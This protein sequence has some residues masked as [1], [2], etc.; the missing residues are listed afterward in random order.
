V[1][2]D[3]A[4]RFQTLVGIGASVA[5]VNA[6]IVEH[7]RKEAL[8]DAMF[9]D[10][11][12]DMLRL[13]NEHGLDEDMAHTAEIVRAAT[14]RLGH[15]PTILMN[16]ASPPPSLKANGSNW[17][18]G[19]PEDCTLVTL[20]DGSFD[21][22]G[23]ASHWRA[24]LE[25]YSALGIEPHYISIQNNPNYVP[26][27]GAANEACRFLP[28]EG[29]TT[30]SVGGE[31]VSIEYPGYAEALD[32]VVA[33]IDDLAAVPQV[34]AP[35]TTNPSQVPEYASALDFDQVDVI[36]H[37]MYGV[38]PTDL[39]I[40]ALTALAELAEEQ[41]RPLFQSEMSGDALTTAVLLHAS[42]A[43]EGA[44]AFVNNGFIESAGSLEPGN[45][46]L[47]NLTE[48]DFVLGDPYHVM[49]HYSAHI[50]PGWVRVAADS[51]TDDVLSSAWVSPDDESMVLV[52]T[53]PNNTTKVVRLDTGIGDGASSS[54]TRTTLNG[55]ERS[56]ELGALPADGNVSLPGRS[57]VTVVFDR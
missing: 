57:M 48:D 52:L 17:C 29:T 50:S 35:E 56:T 8:F 38:D 24:S 30:V 32:A 2:L 15:V 36:A 31:D 33:E 41:G 4:R 37:H 21:Y 5:Y 44:A 19:N 12:L 43:I 47:I 10:T 13:R 18:E 7:P 20:D 23:L 3:D 49:L 42:L 46:V 16:S 6:E 34:L 22:A 27:A 25:A 45:T 55:V 39:N 14:D 11:G 53:N 54:V 28:A 40:E 26:A 9:S 1:T 51:D